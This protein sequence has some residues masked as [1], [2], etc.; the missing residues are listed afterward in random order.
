MVRV[1]EELKDLQPYRPG[2]PVDEV[3]RE[4]GLR[5]VVKLAS[6]ENPFGPSRLALK[7][8]RKNLRE[9]HRYPDGGCYYLRQ[10]LASEHAIPEDRFIFGNGSDE[11]IVL[12]T[13]ALLEKGDTVIIA[14]PTF[15]IYR[16]ASKVAGLKIRSVPLK[17]LRYDLEAMADAVD[18]N[19]RM[20]FVAN[21][22]NPTGTYAN[23]AEVE[24]FIERVPKDVI[25]FFDEAYYEY[26]VGGDY[27]D[28]LAYQ[29]NGNIITTRTF[30]KIYGLAGLRIGYGVSTPDIIELMNKV[31][32]PFNVNSL[33]Q[34]AA[35]AA[36]DDK[37]F[38]NRVRR[39]TDK[40][41]NQL[42]E[43]FKELGINYIP[44]ATNFILVDL[45][46]K[47]EYVYNELMKRGVI[48]RYMA[49]WGLKNYLRVTVGTDLENRKLLQRLRQ[50][51]AS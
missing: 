17:N 6:N 27:P 49:A 50:V 19:T 12:A 16:L 35:L 37:A 5:H 9:I 51:L 32:E 18:G 24:R 45:G 44:S 33:A 22:D 31:R 8:L 40:G 25:L 15:L 2:K 48:T 1:R 28:T 30:S 46:D 42:Y 23:K 21:P 14:E 43:G 10:R 41:K 4:L 36:L 13:R 38:V 39:L 29:N 47:S 34:A 26:A 20:I 7:S 11:L 3:K